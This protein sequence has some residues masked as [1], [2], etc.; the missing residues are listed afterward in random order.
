MTET[1]TLAYALLIVDLSLG[2]HY[3]NEF[4]DTGAYVFESTHQA[5]TLLF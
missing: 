1:L 5:K 3:T 4:Y 2:I